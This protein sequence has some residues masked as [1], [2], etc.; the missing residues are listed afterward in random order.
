MTLLGLSMLVAG[1][2]P[3]ELHTSTDARVVVMPRGDAYRAEIGL[4]GNH[5][6]LR[7]TVASWRTEGLDHAR[8]IEVGGGI[9]FIELALTDEHLVPLVAAGEAGSWTVRLERR[10]GPPP[11]VHE[12]PTVADVLADPP[13]RPAEPSNPLL[14]PLTGDGRAYGLSAPSIRLQVPQDDPAPPDGFQEL[15]GRVDSPTW[16][17]VERWRE[18]VEQLEAPDEVALA[19]RRLAEAH[20]ALGFP[21]EGAY[22]YERAAETG[23]PTAGL[24]LGRADAALMV[25]E[26][27]TA[28]DACTRAA[29]LGGQDEEV[30][31]CLA[32]LSEATGSPAPAVVGRALGAVATRRTARFLAGDLLLR[33]GYATD[34]LPLLESAA[35][36][37][38][39]EAREV[40]WVAVG[41]AALLTGDVERAQHAYQ[42]ARHGRLDDLLRVREDMVAMLRDGVRRWPAWVP[43]LTAFADADGAAAP[44]A[45]YLLAQIHH[46]YE[47][48]ASEAE[49]LGRLWDIHP[50]AREGS[51]VGRRLTAACGARI[52]QLARNGRDADTVTTFE[53]CWRPGLT[54]WVQDTDP[55]LEVSL[56]WERLGLVDR[57]L[58]AQSELTNVLAAQGREEPLPVV[59]LASLQVSSGVPDRALDTL[60]YASRLPGGGEPPVVSAIARVRAEVHDASGDWQAAV[61]DLEVAAR[62]DDLRAEAE[63]RSMLLRLDHEVCD[64]ARPL[65]NVLRAGP[66]EDEPL[67]EVELKVAACLLQEE[68]PERAL[69]VLGWAVDRSQD[70][71]IRQEARWLATA[72][73]RRT[74]APLEDELRSSSVTFAVLDEEAAEDAAWTTDLKAWM[75][76]IP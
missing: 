75:L 59:R 52:G 65:A 12:V 40:A 55:L 68:D 66:L 9:A 64:V 39:E 58:N 30:L 34:A 22:Y 4:Y 48:P 36:E 57:A 35:S 23:V 8:L 31:T 20:V 76:A 18:L 10:R 38:R 62:D 70:E 25:R 74:D 72:V 26:W 71:R 63:R 73:S 49:A 32:I 69:R 60:A 11:V 17:D 1:A 41:D 15:L 33:D 67:G 6:W 42:T 29:E 56:A 2:A 27:G 45:L 16:G 47:D 13:R 51:D 28:R 37:M 44:D 19:Y 53:T 50:A 46:V 5:T 3:L 43:D 14:A 61:A 54:T 21:R 24:W 7:S